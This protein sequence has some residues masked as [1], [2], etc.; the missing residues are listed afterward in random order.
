MVENL[1]YLFETHQKML[2]ENASLQ[3][4]ANEKQSTVSFN[5]VI[6]TNGVLIYDFEL[7]VQ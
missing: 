6:K 3:K 5:E 1:T 4:L 7:Y 2:H